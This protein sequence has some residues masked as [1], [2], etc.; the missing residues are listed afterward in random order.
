[1]ATT[2]K[3][4]VDELNKCVL[5]HGA[6]Q[7]PEYAFQLVMNPWQHPEM[8]KSIHYLFAL[9]SSLCNTCGGVIFLTTD[10]QERKREVTRQVLERFQSRLAELISRKIGIT[11]CNMNFT[12]VPLCIKTSWAAMHLKRSELSSPLRSVCGANLPQ[13]HSNLEGFLQIE[14]TP[15][16]QHARQGPSEVVSSS[17]T[18]ATAENVAES[19]VS[20]PAAER[21]SSTLENK[22]L[23]TSAISRYSTNIPEDFSILQKLDWST[24]KKDWETYVHGETPTIE[25]VVNSCSL[26]KPTT[27]MN[28]TPDKTTLEQWFASLENLE[29]TFSA[30]DTKEPGFALAC[31][32]WTFHI[33]DRERDMQPPGHICDILT[34]SGKGRVCLWVICSE[35]NAQFI[36]YQKEYLLVT[37]RMI[38]YQLI[39]GAGCEDLSD[40]CIECRLFCPNTEAQKLDALSSEMAE[41]LEMQ[42]YIWNFCHH[43]IKFE[44]LQRGLAWIVLS[45]ESPL[46]GP[47]GKQTS[48]TLSAQQVGVLFNKYRVNY[49]SGPAGS[50]KSYT[51]ALLCQMYGKDNSVYICTTT[52]FLEYL[53]YS[54]YPGILVQKDKHLVREIKIGTFQNKQCIIIDDSHNFACT[55]LSMKKLFKLLNGN[56]QMSLFVFADNNYQSFDKKRQQAMRNCIRDLSLQILETEPHYGYLTAIHRNTK[57][58]VSFVQSAIQDSFEDC[59]DIECHNMEIG[60]GIECIKMTNIWVHGQDN[61]LVMYV[62]NICQAETY[63]FTDIAVLLDPSYRSDQIEECRSILKNHI[64]DS[65][66][67]SARVFPRTGVVVDSVTSFLGL[68]APVC[69]FILRCHKTKSFLKGTFKRALTEPNTS[70]C[71]PRF[72]VFMASRATHKAVFVVPRMDAEIA[73]ELKFDLFEVSGSLS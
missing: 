30:V 71:N 52:E 25:T 35:C 7:C 20:G 41:S 31:K 6:L 4:T 29:K 59:L 53:K 22:S 28:V 16:H 38:K 17:Q 60:E 24:N 11:P 54:G 67:Q 13:V 49:I 2:L 50:G 58:V 69:V 23:V 66:I 56:R 10:D 48:I 47:V 8:D 15:D 1:M 5:T 32:T 12:E 18:L 57:K 63:N 62:R 3:Q 39:H 46:K 40:L 72:K 55:K 51:A 61:D 42:K 65:G 44:S 19:D 37:G 21:R 34:V 9:V 14:E 73:K 70:L 64:P 36:T 33:P 27:P 43:G 45:K 68:D 26:W